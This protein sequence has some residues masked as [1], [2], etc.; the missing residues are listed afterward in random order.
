MW[1]RGEAGELGTGRSGVREG[2]GWDV[3]YGRKIQKEKS[4]G[5]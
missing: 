2:R 4:S 5:V 1:G 3:L